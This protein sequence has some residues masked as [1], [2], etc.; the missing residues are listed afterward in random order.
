LQ[1]NF[2][3]YQKCVNRKQLT[4]ETGCAEEVPEDEVDTDLRKCYISRHGVV[5][6]REPDKAAYCVSLYA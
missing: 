6:E 3:I 1:K 2:E 5:S 4:I